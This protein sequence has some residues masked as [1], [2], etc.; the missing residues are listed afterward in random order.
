[1]LAHLQKPLTRTPSGMLL[2]ADLAP[3]P[4]GGGGEGGQP[5]RLALLLGANAVYAVAL[6]LSAVL[7]G[8]ATVALS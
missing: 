8:L 6:L 4:A 2:G 3:A 1:M 7:V 5:H